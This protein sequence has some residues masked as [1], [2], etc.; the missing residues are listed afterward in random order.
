VPWSV[1]RPS[2]PAVGG[3]PGCGPPKTAAA[4]KPAFG[5]DG[6]LLI[7]EAFTGDSNLFVLTDAIAPCKYT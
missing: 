7:N 1:G 5:A 3:D 4:R 6:W 2:R